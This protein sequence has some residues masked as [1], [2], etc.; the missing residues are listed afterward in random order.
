MPY[1][2]KKFM[3][4]KDGEQIGCVAQKSMLSETSSS[5]DWR[6]ILF[7][8]V[9]FEILFNFVRELGFKTAHFIFIKIWGTF[10]AHLWIA[11]LFWNWSKSF[12]I[13]LSAR[14]KT[15]KTTRPQ[16]SGSREVNKAII[17]GISLTSFSVWFS[18]EK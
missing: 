13:D 2:V 17:M 4:L 15:F 16:K 8:K 11:A 7:K 5:A 18:D 12:L 14:T 3:A 9:I 1:F 6:E 10:C